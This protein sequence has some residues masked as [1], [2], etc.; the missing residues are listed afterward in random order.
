MVEHNVTSMNNHNQHHYTSTINN[1]INLCNTSSYTTQDPCVGKRTVLNHSRCPLSQPFKVFF[2][3]VH[4]PSLFVL[5]SPTIVGNVKALLVNHA[6][7][8]NYSSEA[9]VFLVIVGPLKSKLTGEELQNR[10]RSLPFWRENGTNHLLI[11]L[12]TTSALEQINTS[13][14]VIA[15]NGMLFN[16][17]TGVLN[18]YLPPFVNSLQT[19]SSVPDIFDTPR[20]YLL[21]FETAAKQVHND[22]AAYQNTSL[23]AEL[24][25][26][27]TIGCKDSKISEYER[28]L[29]LC[30]PLEKMFY[31]CLQSTFYLILGVRYVPSE[32][33]NAYTY[34]LEALRCGAVPIIVGLDRLPFDHVLEWHRAALILPTLP[35][36]VILSSVLTSLQPQVLMEYRRQGQFL[37]STYFIDQEHITY[38]SIAL[39]RSLFYHPPP[40]SI[41]FEPR[42]I[43]VMNSNLTIASSPRFLNNFSSIHS[44]SMWNSPPGPFFMYPVTPYAPP[45]AP[46]MYHMPTSNKAQTGSTG[47]IQGEEFRAKLRGNYPTEGFTVV[48]LTYHR[49]QHLPSF[50]LN[51]K[52]CPFLS[53]IVLVW[54]NDDD[55]PDDI[56]WPDIGVPIEVSAHF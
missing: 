36:P 21:Y 13:N 48:A 40:P 24:K 55:P 44:S 31:H 3:N 20:R 23:Q 56:G 30:Q 19:F 54:N 34:L 6:S 39:L 8:T 28:K 50:L 26:K 4:F 37:I 17:C 43:K 22:L 25:F 29:G 49:T 5:R 10:I 16:H 18:L 42:T 51:F 2:Y 53:K 9:C 32:Y 27:L 1:Y 11:D 41:D 7:W 15:N 12:E 14:A 52:N 46:E 45:Y 33:I 38:T 35:S 47:H